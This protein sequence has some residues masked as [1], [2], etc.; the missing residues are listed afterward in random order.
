MTANNRLA[1]A[2]AEMTPRMVNLS[3]A[4]VLV[5]VCFDTCG[6]GYATAIL[7]GR[8]E[9]LAWEGEGG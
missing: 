6:I 8:G 9:W 1:I 4:E 5:M 7:E 2:A 3:S